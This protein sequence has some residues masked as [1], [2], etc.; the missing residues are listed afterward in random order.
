MQDLFDLVGRIRIDM[1]GFERGMNEVE[2]RTRSASK[3]LSSVSRNITYTGQDMQARVTA[4]ILAAGKSALDSAIS[5]ESAFAGVRK[6]VDMA[7]EGYTELRKN[8][9]EMS[10]EL[11]ATANEIAS[12][13]E[14][15]GQLGI[16]ND[17]I[18]SFTRTIIDLGESTNLSL[19][20]AGSEFAR[21]ANIV[22]MSQNDF[23][24][25]GS[26]VVA[27][28][29]TMATTESEI[30]SMS[31]RL[32]G[33]GAQLG[34]AEHEIAALAA[35]MSSL[36]IKAE[37]GGTAMTTV[38]KK[39]QRA[40]MDGGASL[41]T[42]AE[43]AQMSSE[44]FKK[45]YDESA[46][47]GLDAVVKGLS[48]ISSRGENLTD[49][50]EDMGIKGIYESDVLLRMSGASDL[51]GE[52]LGTSAKGWEDNTALTNE[53]AERYATTES[54]MRMLKNEVTALAIQ[55]GEI[56]IPALLSI[57]Q[58][59]K[60]IVQRFSEMSDGS[61]KMIVTIGVIAAAIG[62]FLIAIG[63]VI[64]A[65]GKIIGVFSS[66]AGILGKV[67]PFATRFGGIFLRLVAI[68]PR[69]LTP[70]GLISIAIT[71]LI[72]VFKM[73]GIDIVGGIVSGFKSAISWAVEGVKS[74]G[75][76]I[77]DAFKEM[78]GIASPSKLFFQFGRWIIEGLING[79]SAMVDAVVEVFRSL[80][81][82]VVNIVRAWMSSVLQA[83]ANAKEM[84]IQVALMLLSAVVNIFTVIKDA[85]I[86]IVTFLVQ[87][88]INLF[89]TMYTNVIGLIATMRTV[90]VNIVTQ[91]ATA[92]LN[93]F[94][95]II[96]GAV[97]M[98][99]Q[100][101]S[102]VRSA[103]S[104]AWTAATE[105]VSKAFSLG[106]DFVSGIARG[107]SNGVSAVT[108]AVGNV[109]TKAVEKFKNMFDIRSPSRVMSKLAEFLPEGIGQ[110]IENGTNYVAKALSKVAN[111]V[112]NGTEFLKDQIQMPSMASILPAVRRVEIAGVPQRETRR[113]RSDGA[114]GGDT[115][116][117]NVRKLE[118]VS[119]QTI[120]NKVE[121]RFFSK[122]RQRE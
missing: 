56:L 1:S 121:R 51:L 26:T 46:I 19:E 71:G 84:I 41:G 61:K 70:I 93:L 12:V 116:N 16:E 62:P 17:N 58:F 29:N 74:I 3:T 112:T 54:Q 118:D 66:F 75:R 22:G 111:I 57:A 104:R 106:A 89:M 88:V 25:L 13:A 94:R 32:A 65:V 122:A 28:G 27:L 109:A 99:S 37:M 6:T 10:S 55:F 52:S 80:G 42:W 73:F 36:G 90:A 76:A 98:G 72:S 95:R 39:M 35:T 92:L 50:L 23:D 20:Q 82:A 34:M 31:M 81:S 49:V 78:F 68:I 2:S 97:Q 47:A 115:V 48:T 105:F 45:L 101:V 69:L 102:A 53:A 113:N 44:E 4:P 114:S 15:A 14:M 108:G 30:V 24:R 91:L 119:T 59:I 64:G 110:G 77:I 96:Q 83:F 5:F 117:V 40:A 8:I 43:V 60:P 9:L 7:D 21:F 63:A 18:K 87:F 38:L 120:Q 33:Q 79:A 67:I 11:P 85:V 107:I 100:L 86:N 103:F